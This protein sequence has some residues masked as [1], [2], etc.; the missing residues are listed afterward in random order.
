MML[1]LSR[2]LLCQFSPTS[3]SAPDINALRATADPFVT[4]LEEADEEEE[5]DE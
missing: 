1:L 5:D 2:H 4:W 3:V